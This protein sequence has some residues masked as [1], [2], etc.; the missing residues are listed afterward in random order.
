MRNVERAV[1]VLAGIGIWSVSMG[2][3]V[4]RSSG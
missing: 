3:V 4:N 1:A 2:R